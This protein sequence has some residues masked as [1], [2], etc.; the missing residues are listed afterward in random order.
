MKILQLLPDFPF[1]SQRRIVD[2]IG[3]SFFTDFG[4]ICI[5]NIRLIIS[6]A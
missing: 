3:N 2:I 4:T 6:S 1:G 5:S